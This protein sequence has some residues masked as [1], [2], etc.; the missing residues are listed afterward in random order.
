[1]LLGDNIGD[2]AIML[3]P[4]WFHCVGVGISTVLPCIYIYTYIHT[5][6]YTYI[7]T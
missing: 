4:I 7:H 1:M 6:I 3:R 2:R 5:N